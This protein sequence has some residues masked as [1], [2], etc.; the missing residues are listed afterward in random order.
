MLV[1][2]EGSVKIL[3]ENPKYQL[4]IRNFPTNPPP[5]KI[6]TV[7]SAFRSDHSV[8]ILAKVDVGQHM[9]IHST[10]P[11][12]ALVKWNIYHDALNEIT[13]WENIAG[14]PPLNWLPYSI[15]R[16]Q[17]VLQNA[18]AKSCF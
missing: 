5:V 17:T 8:N 9:K 7:T 3:T 15:F 12:R 16:G 14:F 18:F 13:I 1:G 4:K 11:Q 6:L 10:W 2:G